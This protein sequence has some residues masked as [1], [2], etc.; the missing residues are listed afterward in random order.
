LR[1]ARGTK[2][3]V[4]IQDL[5]RALASDVRLADGQLTVAASLHQRLAAIAPSGTIPG[6]QR[7]KVDQRLG[8]QFPS[9][10]TW[11]PTPYPTWCFAYPW[12]KV[13]TDLPDDPPTR[14]PNPDEVVSLEEHGLTDLN[15]DFSA[16]CFVLAGML[17]AT[18]IADYR[19]DRSENRPWN[20]A[21][22]NPI[23]VAIGLYQ[24]RSN[25]SIVSG[26]R[27]FRGSGQTR[28]FEDL[29]LRRAIETYGFDRAFYVS[30][31]SIGPVIP[32]TINENDLSNPSATWTSGGLLSSLWSAINT[33]SNIGPD[34]NEMWRTTAAGPNPFIDPPWNGVRT[35]KGDDGSYRLIAAP[36]EIQ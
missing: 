9:V 33:T 24:P 4:R 10:G 26:A 11:I 35:G 5:Q 23:I 3:A 22:G 32:S 27:T 25:S 34:G 19:S 6:V 17:D 7:F 28:T 36:M 15:P 21:W 20:D 30:A 8:T 2:T 29:F 31:G 1:A 16:E 12:G 14:H 18:Q 13:P